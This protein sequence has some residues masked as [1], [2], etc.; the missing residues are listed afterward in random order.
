MSVDPYCLGLKVNRKGAVR[1]LPVLSL[2]AVRF[3]F[4]PSS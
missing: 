1:P 3:R 4:S 2:P